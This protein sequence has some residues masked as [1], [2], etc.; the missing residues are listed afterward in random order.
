[1]TKAKQ[2]HDWDMTAS[3]MALLANINRDPKKQKTFNPTDFH[4]FRESHKSGIRLRAD[5]ISALK[6]MAQGGKKNIH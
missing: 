4:P 5:N 2:I 3:Q 6:G 1:M